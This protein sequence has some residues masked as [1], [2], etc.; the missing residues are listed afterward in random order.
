MIDEKKIYG[1]VI[2]EIIVYLKK[3]LL[4]SST[5]VTPVKRNKIEESHGQ[6][7]GAEVISADTL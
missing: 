6:V 7:H 5:A 4:N 3:A 2:K 1:L